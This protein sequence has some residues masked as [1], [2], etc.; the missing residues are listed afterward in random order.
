[1]TSSG[2]TKSNS[3]NLNDPKSP[4]NF[5]DMENELTSN[6][7]DTGVNLNSIDQ[8]NIDLNDANN[9]LAYSL[10]ALNILAEVFI[11]F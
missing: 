5:S 1:M 10:Q 3:N 7:S 2:L 4:T 11:S 9:N 8:L 6:L